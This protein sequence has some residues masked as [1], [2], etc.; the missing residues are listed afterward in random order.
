MVKSAEPRVR[1]KREIKKKI[2]K[3]LVLSLLFAAAP[4]FL[5]LSHS[6]HNKKIIFVLILFAAVCPSRCLPS[7]LLSP[8]C[9]GV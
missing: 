7:Q 6:L 3:L 9:F 1:R 2:T 4:L 8:I 5:A